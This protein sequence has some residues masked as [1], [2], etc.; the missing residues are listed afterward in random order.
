MLIEMVNRT[1][2][3]LSEAIGKI[4]DGL[5]RT[6]FY[7]SSTDCGP[8]RA[9]GLVGGLLVNHDD[10]EYFKTTCDILYVDTMK[11]VLIQ[12]EKGLLP[13]TVEVLE[14]LAESQ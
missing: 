11:E 14:G 9:I 8:F 13:M 2:S 6:P 12:V 3:N 10:G 7:F 5:F 4:P 1:H